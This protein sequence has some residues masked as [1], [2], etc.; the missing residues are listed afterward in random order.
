M[1]Y[2]GRLPSGGCWT[3]SDN[4]SRRRWNCPDARRDNSRISDRLLL[5][6]VVLIG[7]IWFLACQ[8]FCSF[9]R[10]N[11]SVTAFLIYSLRLPFE[12]LSTWSLKI[13]GSLNAV[14]TV[15]GFFISPRFLYLIRILLH[16]YTK[17]KRQFQTNF[18]NSLY[19]GMRVQALL[20]TQG[21]QILTSESKSFFGQDL[22]LTA[23]L[24]RSF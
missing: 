14:N 23:G 15:S 4:P 10:S 6:R 16:C 21:R 18:R 7:I 12:T 8:T 22:G 2:L 13:F 24:E 17:V 3:R 19:P 20:I 11:F 9:S 5:L 1:G